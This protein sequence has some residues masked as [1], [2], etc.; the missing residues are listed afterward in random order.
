[1]TLQISTITGQMALVDEILQRD[2]ETTLNNFFTYQRSN[3]RS[4]D[5]IARE[6]T[7]L[8]DVEGFNVTYQTARRWCQRMDIW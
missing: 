1:M 6:L 4:F 7:V 5:S 8:V 3:R 2:H